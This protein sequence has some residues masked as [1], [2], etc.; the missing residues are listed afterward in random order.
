MCFW[1]GVCAFQGK[2]KKKVAKIDDHFYVNNHKILHIYMYMFTLNRWKPSENIHVN[3]S[4]HVPF[5][6]FLASNL[7]RLHWHCFIKVFQV[8]LC[9]KST[10]TLLLSILDCMLHVVLWGVSK[11]VTP[12][13][14][15]W[16]FQKQSL[17]EAV[18]AQQ[19]SYVTPFD[20]DYPQLVR[21]NFVIICLV[22]PL[23]N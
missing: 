3:Q 10:H 4:C 15:Y 2:V 22:F 6:R 13:L 1:L 8:Q 18:D 14:H 9:K 11:L 20:D 5:S 12:V 7:Q 21:I 23:I 17:L 16:S 19:V